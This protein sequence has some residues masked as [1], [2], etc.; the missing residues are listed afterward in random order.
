MTAPAGATVISTLPFDATVVID[1]AT[2]D[3]LDATLNE[4][5]GAPATEGSVWYSFDATA[6]GALL[7]D[8]SGSSFTAGALVTVGDPANGNVLTCGPETIVFDVVAGES[9]L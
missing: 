2:T 6:H 8:I 1:E 7:F 3:A 4:Q 9:Y 5:C